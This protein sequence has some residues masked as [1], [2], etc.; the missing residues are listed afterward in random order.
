MSMQRLVVLAGQT[1]AAAAIA[2]GLVLWVAPAPVQPSAPAIA[3]SSSAEATRPREF[4]TPL[5]HASYRGAVRAAKPS[6]VNIYTAKAV[7][8]PR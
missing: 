4:V 1:V 8:R 6:V 5:D 2:A 3:T 7:R